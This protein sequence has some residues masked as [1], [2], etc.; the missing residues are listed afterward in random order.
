[1]NSLYFFPHGLEGKN[2]LM[3]IETSFVH[4]EY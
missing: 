4:S 2:V 3:N 1:M